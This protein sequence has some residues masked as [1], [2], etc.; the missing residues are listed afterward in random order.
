MCKL[1]K[2]LPFSLIGRVMVF[3]TICTGSIPVKAAKGCSSIG[4]TSV[5]HTECYGFKS[6]TSIFFPI[7][8]MAEQWPFK[9]IT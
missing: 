8:S 5:L 6:F 4:R 2:N 9:P 1:K 3:E 7:S